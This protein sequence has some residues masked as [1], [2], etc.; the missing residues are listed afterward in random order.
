M[1]GLDWFELSVV[2]MIPCSLRTFEKCEAFTMAQLQLMCNR[3]VDSR[4]PILSVSL[5]EGVVSCSCLASCGRKQHSVQ[6]RWLPWPR[7]KAASWSSISASEEN[8][9]RP[10]RPLGPYRLPWSSGGGWLTPY[11]CKRKGYEECISASVIEPI[12]SF[13]RDGWAS[14]ALCKRQRCGESRHLYLSA[15]GKDMVSMNRSS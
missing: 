14:L 5:R 13:D 3:R 10:H 11:L 15:S 4:C 9:G 6:P 8:M 2:S 1:S 7:L 12:T